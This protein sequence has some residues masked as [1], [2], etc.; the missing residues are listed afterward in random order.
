MIITEVF[1]AGLVGEGVL[2]MLLHAWENLLIPP[3]E[4]TSNC[5]EPSKNKGGIVLP[6]S[7]TVWVAAIQCINIARRLVAV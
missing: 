2:P 6:Y 5:K 4:V 1:D 3:T 7:A